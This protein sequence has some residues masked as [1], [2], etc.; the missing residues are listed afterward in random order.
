MEN[1]ILSIGTQNGSR[2]II[3]LALRY[4][5]GIGAVNNS[6]KTTLHFAFN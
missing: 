6:S 2:S 5:A 3:K 1:G 4:G